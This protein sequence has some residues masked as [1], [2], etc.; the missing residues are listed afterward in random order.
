MQDEQQTDVQDEQQTDA[1]DE[2]QANKGKITPP[3]NHNI[4]FVILGV[5]YS[6]RPTEELTAEDIEI[7]VTYVKNRIE[8]YT[9]KGYDQSRI[10]ILVAFDIAN[11]LRE[12][13]K[14]YELPIN[15]AIDKLKFVL[16]PE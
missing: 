2:Q 7:L 1:Q 16:E 13:Q 5:S 8:N 11:E 6:I 3:E 15:R 14:F 4:R 12:L 9:K 10:P